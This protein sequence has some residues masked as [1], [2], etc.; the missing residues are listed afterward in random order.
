MT[1]TKLGPALQG[2]RVR[3]RID[4]DGT[5]NPPQL[6]SATIMRKLTGTDGRSY[7]LVRL[8]QPVKSLRWDTRQEWILNELAVINHFRDFPLEELFGTTVASVPVRILNL[9]TSLQTNVAVLD[10]SKAVEFAR[11]M[12]SLA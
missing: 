4:E 1:E 6:P 7:Y 8:D 3:L 9:M 10:L 11:G 12:I 5:P 2:V